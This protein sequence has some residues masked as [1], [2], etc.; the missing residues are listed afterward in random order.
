MALFV[1]SGLITQHRILVKEGGE[2]FQEAF[3]LNIIIFDKISMLTEGGNLN[4]INHNIITFSIEET[5]IIW[6]IA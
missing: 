2:T 6:A 3:A 1:D 4:I 5:K